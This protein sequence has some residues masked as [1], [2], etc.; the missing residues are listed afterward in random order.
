MDAFDDPE[1]F[2]CG[3]FNLL[4]VAQDALIREV[5]N[6]PSKVVKTYFD[7]PKWFLMLYFRLKSLL[8]GSGLRGHRDW[9]N[10]KVLAIVPPRFIPGEDGERKQLYLGRIFSEIPREQ[11]VLMYLQE[12]KSAPIP[13]DVSKLQVT[14]AFDAAVPDSEE[15]E[16]LRNLNNCFKLLK[17]KN[18][19]SSEDLE[20]I[21]V[22][23]DE[24]W[25]NYRVMDRFA[26]ELLVK[27]ALLIPGYYTEFLIAALKKHRIEVVELQHGV[28][29]PAS[30]F[31]IYPP[32]IKSVVNRALFPD[33]IWTFGEFWKAQLL[34]GIGYE[35]DQ[36]QVLGDY[37]V[38]QVQPPAQVDDFVDFKKRFSKLLLVGTQTKRHAHFNR[39]V[40]QLSKKYASQNAGIGIVVKPHP[41]EDTALYAEISER[42]NVLFVEA[43]LDFLYPQC[44]AYVSMYSN[45]LFESLRHKQLQRFVLM[46]DD[47]LELAK[48][49]AESG[50][51]R[52]LREDEDPFEMEGK[53]DEVDVSYFFQSELNTDLLKRLA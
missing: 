11:M 42:E 10:R 33:R 5:A 43:S 16:V 23:F 28:I 4:K 18:L 34:K 13:P 26:G 31:Y 30:H 17:R 52:L 2:D 36:I 50:V 45:T 25:R 9:S 21:K 20:H 3:E 29:T 47:T 41:A 32:K 1:V 35:P 37:F 15:W 24:F 8:K 22:G 46:S 12:D 27:T 14:E 19:F 39:F 6:K 51:A 44:D 40:E 38:R 48:G 7:K 53:S 49:I